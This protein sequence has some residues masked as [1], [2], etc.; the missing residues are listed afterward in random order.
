M[1]S[2][3]VAAGSVMA[4]VAVALLAGLSLTACQQP[5]SDAVTT[6][7]AA[8]QKAAD[9]F[10]TLAKGSETT[11]QP[12]RQTDAAAAPLLNAV[13]DT[14][15]L[16]GKPT[17]PIADLDAANN[18]MLACVKVGQVY[19]FAGTGTT[20]P[21][22]A[23]NPVVEAKAEANVTAFAP[24]VGRYADAELT[25]MNAVDSMLSA[26]LAANPAKANDPTTA[27]GLSKVRG[28]TAT[29]VA[30]VIGMLSINGVTDDWRRARMPAI[31]AIAPEAAKLLTADQKTQLNNTAL[32]VAGG[33]D[34]A[35]LKAQLT[36][37]AQTVQ[38]AAAPT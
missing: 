3:W 20:D 8:A 10:A 19:M 13:L 34:D 33:M 25:L 26:D 27:D 24:E 14:S 28:G 38:G 36:T 21:A 23:S 32:T 2:H 9:Q 12:P 18:W 17:P 37:F 11:D 7:S 29:A 5:A 22:Q 35:G 15:V 6:A 4:G 1:K 30:A 31:L 16:A